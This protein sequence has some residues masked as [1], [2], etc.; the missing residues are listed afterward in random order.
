MLTHHRQP[1][2][3][4]WISTDLPVWSAIKTVA[5]LDRKDSERFHLLLI[6]P[7]LSQEQSPQISTANHLPLLWVEISPYRVIMT[8][9]AIGQLN[10]RHYWEQ[11]VYG[12]SRYWLNIP[13]QYSEPLQLR[14]YTRRLTLVGRP[15]PQKLQVEY[16][17]WSG[18]VQ[19]GNYVL[20][21]EIYQ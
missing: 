16:E 21:L 15:I 10:Y 17:L 11:G 14:N 4:S 2:S 3:L 8:R 18:D 19:F 1:I 9:Q 20:N 7:S 13:M 5:T 12:V 6:E